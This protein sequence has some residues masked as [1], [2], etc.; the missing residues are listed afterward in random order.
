MDWFY[1]PFRSP[2][3]ADRPV[4]FSVGYYRG[5]KRVVLAWFAEHHDAQEFAD[6]LRRYNP[7]YKIDV[8]RTL[9]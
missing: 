2:V 1:C 5:R 8:L 4:R 9:F 7:H 6:R 3:E